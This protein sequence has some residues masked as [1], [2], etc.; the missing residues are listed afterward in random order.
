MVTSF[1]LGTE[2]QEQVRETNASER[3]DC[4]RC[5]ARRGEMNPDDSDDEDEARLLE[6]LAIQMSLDSMVIVDEAQTTS[7][8]DDYGPDVE[9]LFE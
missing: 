5:R 8:S 2:Q 3:C 1:N 4:P 6:S 9:S 7:W